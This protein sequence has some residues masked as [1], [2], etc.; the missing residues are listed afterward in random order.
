[1]EKKLRKGYGHMVCDQGSPEV[2]KLD[3]IGA[4]SSR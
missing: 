2:P 1:M 3:S 4:T